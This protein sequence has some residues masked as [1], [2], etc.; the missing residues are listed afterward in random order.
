[1]STPERCRVIGV[2]NAGIELI[3]D[4]EGSH[5]HHSLVDNLTFIR[6]VIGGHKGLSAEAVHIR[7]SL[8]AK[9]R[10]GNGLRYALFELNGSGDISKCF[11]KF[12]TQFHLLGYTVERHRQRQFVFLRGVAS[13][14]LN[15]RTDEVDVRALRHEETA[16]RTVAT[17]SIKSSQRR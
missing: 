5:G 10:S 15:G 1:M 12:R 4:V 3:D 2:T 11:S 8:E 6:L 14:R 17:I 7:N 16:D 13:D 9:L